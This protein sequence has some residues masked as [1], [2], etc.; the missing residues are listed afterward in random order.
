MKIWIRQH[1]AALAGAF[2][3][4]LTSRGSFAL[5]VLVVSIALALPI[6][7]L[8]VLDNLQPVSEEL[9][10]EP[11]ISLFLTMATSRDSAIALAPAIRRVLQD[12]KSAGKID[13]VARE[14]ALESLKNK[15]GMADALATLGANP[16]PDAYVLT[17]AG[18]WSAGDTKKID[19]LTTQLQA[20]PNV[21]Y[22][23]IDSAWIKRLIALLHVL[24]LMLLFLAMTLGVVVVAVI[25]NTIRLQ[26]LTQHDEIKV[27]R[28]VGATDSF[29]Y[30][31]FYYT[32][33]LLGLVSGSVALGAVAWGLA[34]LNDAITQF[35]QLYGSQFRLMPL[36][37]TTSALILTVGT[38]L[39]LF[40]SLLSV[41][42]HLARLN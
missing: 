25:F 22:V 20:L 1:M 28:L 18:F 24:R 4:M 31:P 35:A 11:E 27:S 8:T 26:V 7:G 29:I 6:A 13:F 23:Q 21:E 34:P 32:G 15:T 14:K 30:R 9:A 39:G 41:Q 12:N 36:N 19:T 16:L 10:V 38:M 5:N 17:L 33:A 2:G 40:G 3:H 42:R 37:F